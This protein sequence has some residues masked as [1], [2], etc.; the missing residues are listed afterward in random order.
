M[1]YTRKIAEN[2]VHQV[3]LSR[4][5]TSQCGSRINRVA[6]TGQAVQMSVHRCSQFIAQNLERVF[7]DWVLPVTTCRVVVVLQQ[8]R[9]PLTDTALHIEREKDRLRERF[10]NFGSGVVRNL[11]DRG[12]L[13]DLIDPRTGYPQLSRPGEIAHDDTAVVKALLGL[14]IVQNSCSV[15]EHPSWGSAV[16]PGILMSSASEQVIKN[17]LKKVAIQHSWKEPKKLQLSV[18]V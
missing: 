15:L 3:E 18:E 7:P 10:I 17:V 4:L 6:E 11:R 1:V 8:S 13:T 14:P 2:K 16:Y 12:F 5:G 9:Y